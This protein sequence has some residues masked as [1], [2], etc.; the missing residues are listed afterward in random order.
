MIVQ[1][2]NIGHGDWTFSVYYNISGTGEIGE[3]YRSLLREGCPPENAQRAAMELSRYN[4]GYTW[5]VFDSHT[6]MI[7]LSRTTS[8]EQ[9]FDSIVHE[10]KHA[11]EHISE[12][13]GV[14]PGGEESAYL[15]GEIGRQM[16]PAA[17]LVVCP[18]RIN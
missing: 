17:A 18:Y 5:T 16:F 15:Q 9:M 11:V 2:F 6:T 1:R 4:S 10:L 7:F 8:Q 12:Y 3:V 14:D 13:Y